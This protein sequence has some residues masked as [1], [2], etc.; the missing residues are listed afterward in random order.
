VVKTIFLPWFNSY[1]YFVEQARRLRKK[2]G[3]SF[4]P[5]PDAYKSSS[6]IMDKWI[7]SYLQSLIKFVHEEMKGYRLYTVIPKLV[8]F[9]DQMSRWYLRFN[10]NRLKGSQGRTDCLNSLTILYEVLVKIC[11][12]MAPFTPFLVETMYLNLRKALPAEERVGSVHFT[13][14]PNV[15]RDAFNNRVE[16]VSL[17]VASGSSFSSPISSF[18][19]VLGWK[20][21][22]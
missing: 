3:I 14:I 17:A 6:N 22:L 13:S 11:S 18:V 15:N 9:I 20:F 21:R 10:K 8:D 19:R 5:N 2:D 1:R 12:L 7:I 16:E 4:K